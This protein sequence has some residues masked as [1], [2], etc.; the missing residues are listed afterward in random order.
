MEN[1]PKVITRREFIAQFCR[2]A[3]LLVAGTTIGSLVGRTDASGMVWQLDP[4]KCTQC[5]NCATACVLVLQLGY[6]PLPAHHRSDL[7]GQGRP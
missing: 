2:G 4:D 1:T 5:G 6:H 7:G 3:G